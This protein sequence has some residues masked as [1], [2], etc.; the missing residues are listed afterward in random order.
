MYRYAIH[1]RS[2]ENEMLREIAH[3]DGY[4]N[5]IDIAY[6]ISN[7][8]NEV[9]VTDNETGVILLDIENGIETIVDSLMVV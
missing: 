2:S 9:A 7:H 4:Y 8:L 5:A 1:T 6:A 3:V